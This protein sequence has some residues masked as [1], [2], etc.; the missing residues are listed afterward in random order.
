MG[1]G[2]Q[3]KRPPPPQ[4]RSIV[5]HRGSP[6]FARI[7]N[8]VAHRTIGRRLRFSRLDLAQSAPC[9]K[10]RAHVVRQW[11]PAGEQKRRKWWPSGLTRKPSTR[12]STPSYGLSSNQYRG[13][14]GN[15]AAITVGATIGRGASVASMRNQNGSSWATHE[16]L[17]FTVAPSGFAVAFSGPPTEMLGSSF[18]H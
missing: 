10:A 17:Q 18:R 14:P 4:P 12:A 15:F 16:G 3:S 5:E 2:R 8:P 13:L 11:T 9:G 1:S 6:R 7:R